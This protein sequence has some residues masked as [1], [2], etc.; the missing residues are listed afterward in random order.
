M[1]SA[2]LACL[3]IFRVA[4]GPRPKRATNCMGLFT[5]SCNHEP[6]FGMLTEQFA[7]SVGLGEANHT[8]PMTQF[9]AAAVLTLVVAVLVVATLLALRG[10]MA[11]AVALLVA[12]FG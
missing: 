6:S 8:A 2:A 1:A 7:S 5:S 12:M 11:G 4:S 9:T 3:P 10:M